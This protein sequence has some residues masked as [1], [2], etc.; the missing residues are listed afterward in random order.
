MGRNLTPVEDIYNTAQALFPEKHRMPKLIVITGGEPFRQNITNLVVLLRRGGAL[1]Q[2]ETNGTFA[3]PDGFPK[4]VRVVCSPKARK[5]AT[6][7]IPFIAA[8]K[9]VLDAH[10]VS[11]SD[12]LPVSILGRGQTPARP[13][14]GFEGAVYV[15]PMDVQDKEL[16]EL[17]VQTTVQV[18]KK[19]GYILNLQLHK[20]VGLP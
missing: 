1:V 3:P 12:G 6:G 20:I 8:Y 14:E 4:G 16:N 5:V 15:S 9:Y 19:Y 2:I 13:H 11:T 7:L 17:N 18:C 10:A